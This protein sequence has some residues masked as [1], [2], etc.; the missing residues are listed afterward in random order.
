MRHLLFLRF[1]G[2][3]VLALLMGSTTRSPAVKE[4]DFGAYFAAY[5]LRGSFLVLDAATRQ[6]MAYD[7]ARC[8]QGFLPAS[9]FKIPNTLIGLETGVVR[10]TAEVFRWDGVTR[11]FP[12]WNRD[13]SFAQALRVSCVPCYQ[14][15]ARR[16]GAERYQQW[17]PRLRF[18]SMRVTP[19]SVD[20]FWL[21][22][23]SRITQFEQIDFLQRLQR[24]KLPVARRTQDLTKNMLILSRG[25]G[26]VLRGK[27]GWTMQQGHDNGWFV[28]WVEQNGKAYFFALNAE[29]ADGKP[30]TAQ[31]V[32]GR[33]AITEQILQREFGLLAGPAK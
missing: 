7:V 10:D 25:P 2:L 33:R 28:G 21:T 17:L 6:F 19:A 16:V 27:T 1:A 30:A 29:P 18:G 23:P 5:G 20:T 13:M 12:Q 15:L 31:F 22:G 9:T 24:G 8:R 11:S 32:Q 3:L 14:Q 4:R 26:W